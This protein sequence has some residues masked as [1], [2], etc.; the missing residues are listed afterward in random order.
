MP[1]I[2][3]KR[4][5]FRKFY[6]KIKINLGGKESFHIAQ[7][8]EFEYDGTVLKYGG[9]EINTLSVRG[10]CEKGEWA[11]EDP[12][13]DSMPRAVVPERNRAKAQSVNKDLS[14]VAR[15]QGPG[16]ET[17]HEDEQTVLN[18]SD[19]RAQGSGTKVLNVPNDRAQPRIMKASDNQRRTP[20]GMLL[21]VSAVDEQEGVT[22][23]TVRTPAKLGMV[24]MTKD[25]SYNI[26]NTL[27]DR[28]RAKGYSKVQAGTVGFIPNEEVVQEGI[29]IKSNLSKMDRNRPIDIGQEDD[30]VVVGQVRHTDR[31]LSSGDITVKDT[32]N[33]SKK[34]AAKQSVKKVVTKKVPVKKTTPEIEINL[35]PKIRMARKFDPSFPADWSFEG[36]LSERLAAVKRHGESPEFLEALFAAEGDQMRKVLMAEYPNQFGG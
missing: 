32:S 36:K 27:E 33:K 31:R 4:G 28:N 30:G 2:K 21:D 3:W 13:D 9:T 15:I 6:A 29:S 8:D 25:S 5:E 35:S 7:Y 26:S 34:V 1:V 19:R 20:G 16:L 18:V 10:V 23:G 22:V 24:D 12:N 14:R 17:D 11:S